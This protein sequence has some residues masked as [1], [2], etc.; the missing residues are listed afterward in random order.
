MKI[1]GCIF[2]SFIFFSSDFVWG[3]PIISIVQSP[4]GTVIPAGENIIVRTNILSLSSVDNPLAYAWLTTDDWKHVKEIRST[5]K[6]LLSNDFIIDFG[7]FKEGQHIQYTVF[8]T[9]TVSKE[10][11]WIGYDLK[12]ETKN[13]ASDIIDVSQWR[14]R[15]NPPDRFYIRI[16]GS[17]KINLESAFV[18]LLPN[19]ELPSLVE[20]IKNEAQSSIQNELIVNAPF[21]KNKKNLYRVQY[22]RTD[23]SSIEEVS[24]VFNANDIDIFDEIQPEIVTIRGVTR[25]IGYNPQACEIKNWEQS[26]DACHCCLVKYFGRGGLHFLD[27]IETI[28]RNTS[29]CSH[30]NI[31]KIQKEF[32]KD[33][34]DFS[35][36]EN[37]YKNTIVIPKILLDKKIFDHPYLD[38]EGVRGILVQAQSEG[39]IQPQDFYQKTCIEVKNIKE[40]GGLNTES[41]FSITTTCN[42]TIGVQHYIVKESKDA[43]DEAVSLER[44]SRF[45][46]FSSIILPKRIP[47]FPGISLPLGYISYPIFENGRNTFH[48]LSIQS[49]AS[50]ENFCSFIQEQGKKLPE[51]YE[52]IGRAYI[53]LGLQLANFHLLHMDKRNSDS[54]LTKTVIHGDLKCA[55][56]FYNRETAEFTLID[57]P[58]MERSFLNKKSPILDIANILLGHLSIGEDEKIRHVLDHI[59]TNSWY[60]NSI[61]NFLVGYSSAFQPSQKKEVM[62]DL[63]A[64]FN[65]GF[66]ENG[67]VVYDETELKNVLLLY[68]NPMFDEFFSKEEELISELESKL[69]TEGNSKKEKHY[70]SPRFWGDQVVYSVMVDRFR[71]GD[72]S[73]DTNNISENQKVEEKKRDFSTIGK[74]RHGG[75]IQGIIDRLDYIVEL[76]VSTLMVTSIFENNNGDYHG[77][78]V[79]DFTKVDPNFGTNEDFTR[80]VQEAHKRGLYVILDVVVNHMC[81]VHSKYLNR[82]TPDAHIKCSNELSEKEEKNKKM[83]SKYSSA[84]DFSSDFHKFFKNQDYFNRCGKNTIDETESE[85][86]VSFYGDFSSGMFDLNTTNYALQKMLSDIMENWIRISDVDGF[87]LDAVKHISPTFTAY[88]STKI[89]EFASHLGKDNFGVFGEIAGTSKLVSLHLGKMEGGKSKTFDDEVNRVYKKENKS[90]NQ[91]SRENKKFPFL[92]LNGVYEFGHSGNAVKVLQNSRSPETLYSY[93]EKE[94]YRRDLQREADLRN[95]MVQLEIHDWPRFGAYSPTDP[96]KSRLGLQYLAVAEGIPLLYYGQEQG[97]TG[98][99]PNIQNISSKEGRDVLLESCRKSSEV[100]APDYKPVLYDE[101]YRQDM[102]EEGVWKLG[103]TVDEINKLASVAKK[104]AEKITLTEEYNWEIDPFLSRNHFVY[105]EA[106]KFLQIRKSC[107]A[108][109]WGLTHWILHPKNDRDIFA[110]L[111]ADK[112]NWKNQILVVVN[113][114]FTS[115]Q[116]PDIAVSSEL[117][118]KKINSEN[119]TLVRI[120]N[121]NRTLKFHDTKIEGNSVQLYIPSNRDIDWDQEYQ[122]NLCVTHRTGD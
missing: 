32:N 80:L 120:E 91:I 56:L 19:G 6:D 20:L 100:T 15:N 30:G 70:P 69:Q 105:Q 117:S 40:L 114:N 88:F 1:L 101:F 103:S 14:D 41:L 38:E 18:Q 28:C 104:N 27:K 11:I 106:R 59:D 90:L 65:S 122:T 111:R 102:F 94:D 29:G 39:K 74:H 109:R 48:T 55:N 84:I 96:Y 50:G 92:G 79:S 13:I 115:Q 44:I 52:E 37:L 75:D 116:I 3:K 31:E 78:C 82:I 12:F 121:T 73:N 64:L 113:T 10:K 83:Y 57:N 87:R 61:S 118:F 2:F 62:K 9:H 54:V 85:R 93:F 108:L 97:F 23:S 49:R 46:S 35:Y 53:N 112:F 58:S 110:F 33:P 45:P 22:Q 26:I 7:A 67:E 4:A 5:K 66:S 81:D 16:R 77:Y 107:P 72:R 24:N 60:K 95:S 51:S 17:N 42:K 86:P 71:N 8:F 36:I 98:I 47:D 43:E 63:Q 68:I 25:E 34:H 76:G 119:S 21:Y 99:C 89:R